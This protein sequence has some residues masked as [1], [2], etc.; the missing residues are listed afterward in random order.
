MGNQSSMGDVTV[1]ELMDDMEQ[2]AEERLEL[3]QVLDTAK[4]MRVTRDA[5]VTW[6]EDERRRERELFSA[7]SR[8]PI[9]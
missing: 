2:R 8:T 1:N 4:M 9:S 7:L 3:L 5:I 6:I